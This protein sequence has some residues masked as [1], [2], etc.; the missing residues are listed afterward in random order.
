[1]QISSDNDRTCA[2][3]ARTLRTPSASVLLLF[4]LS[5]NHR[6]LSPRSFPIRIV[7]PF[8]RR[9]CS[10]SFLE[11]ESFGTPI[12]D[13]RVTRQIRTAMFSLSFFLLFFLFFFLGRFKDRRTK[14]SRAPRQSGESVHFQSACIVHIYIQIYI[15]IYSLGG[16]V[17]EREE[18]TPAK[19]LSVFTKSADDKEK[20]IARGCDNFESFVDDDSQSRFSDT[21]HNA[22]NNI[23]RQKLKCNLASPLR[24]KSTIFVN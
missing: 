9:L 19:L 2:H 21:T 23:P 20:T 3:P 5:L 15:R 11:E 7:V 1:M 10:S 22:R 17:K 13:S 14:V 8:P 12:R 18:F 24:Q 4:P 6:P 16:Q